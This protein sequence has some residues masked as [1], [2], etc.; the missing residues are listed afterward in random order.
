MKRLILFSM[1]CLV[2]IASNAQGINGRVID[3]QAQ[4]MPFANVVLVCK[5][6]SAFIAGVV[7]K[8]DGTFS[9]STDKQDG[10]L[11]VSCIGYMTR[12]IDARTGIANPLELGD[13]RMQPDTQM[14]G[15]VTVKGH[16]PQF[17]MG[18]E[19]F[20]TNV[21]N[22][23]LSQI[24]T[25][26]DVLR[27]VP[28]IIAKDGVYEVFGKGSPIIYINGRKMRN[29][30]ELEQLKSTDIKSIELITNPVAKYD[31]TVGAIVKIE[32]IRRAGDGFSIDTWGRWR[33]GRKAQESASLDMNYRHNG[34][35][36]FTSLWVSK[37]K[38]LQQSA[39]TQEIQSDTL[40]QQKNEMQTDIVNHDYSI[41]GG[42]NYMLNEHHRFG[43]KYEMT[44]PSTTDEMT[45]LTS[46]VMANGH[47]YD[48]WQNMT[49][50]QTKGIAG[51]KMNAYY[52]AHIAAKTHVTS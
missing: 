33:Q 23:P 13:I 30:K 24:G 35:D 22:T 44:L 19:G 17:Q 29:K 34:L 47:F 15:E 21:T 20:V 1:M 16:V 2:A 9:I 6:D 38:Y 42:F 8:D 28:G 37:G 32:T 52:L 27:H 4:P 49:N 31:A 7:T 18:S 3:E 14:L 26:D 45:V 11:K 46:D 5:A 43:M 12:Y 50:K 51:Q 25:A 40:W 48:K 39:I 10:L 36:I 41:E